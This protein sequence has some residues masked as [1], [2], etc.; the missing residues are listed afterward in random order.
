PFRPRGGRQPRTPAHHF[1]K[2]VLF[3]HVREAPVQPPSQVQPSVPLQH[4][5]RLPRT[6][7]MATA[8]WKVR[9]A[10]RP[11]GRRSGT[12][13]TNLA[14]PGLAREGSEL[15]RDALGLEEQPE[16]VAPAGL[17]VGARHVESAERVDAHQRAR[18]LPV[19]VEVP[20]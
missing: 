10:H 12:Q 6:G 15:L 4:P 20:A 11:E 9:A 1:R 5:E 16:V 13:V 19:D 17:A 18:A 3:A 2:N 14:S 7:G 8:Y